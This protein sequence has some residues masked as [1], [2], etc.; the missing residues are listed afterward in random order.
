MLFGEDMGRR[1]ACPHPFGA[2]S[3]KSRDAPHLVARV[4]VLV[5]HIAGN[6]RTEGLGNRIAR[7]PHGYWT[8]P[9]AVEYRP[10]SEAFRPGGIQ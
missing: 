4:A 6:M 3:G 1:G 9:G 10:W 2:I 7:G 8:R 5:R